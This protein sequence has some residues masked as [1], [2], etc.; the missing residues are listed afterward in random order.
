MKEKNRGEDSVFDLAREYADIAHH[1]TVSDDVLSHIPLTKSVTAVAR[2]VSNVRDQLL[3]R[4][5]EKYL[6][7]VAEVPGELRRQMVETLQSDPE[8]GRNIGEHVIELLERVESNFKPEMIG[9]VFA[10]FAK[11]GISIKMLH[12]L[13]D[14]IERLR[15][16]EIGALRR[17][18]EATPTER[19]AMDPESLIALLTAGL[20]ELHFTHEGAAYEPSKTGEMFVGLNLDVRS[21]DLESMRSRDPS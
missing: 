20:I 15:T 19:S 13:N 10:A 8:Y 5:L 4:K 12:R 9:Y 14:A 16:S 18:V 6:V 11:G 2:F 7:A 3:M 21:I 17:Y 1:E